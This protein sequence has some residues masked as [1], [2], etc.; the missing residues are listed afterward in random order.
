MKS[1]KKSMVI[2]TVLMVLLLIVAL[3][4]ATFAWYSAQ[5]NASVTRTT[6]SSASSNS[7][8]LVVDT[9]KVTDKEAHQSTV[10][11]TM[12]ANVAPMMLNLTAET[13]LADITYAD[14]IAKF[15]TY[16][17]DNAGNYSALP[18]TATPGVI[19]TVVGSTTA[20]QN[21]FWVTNVGGINA[22][23]TANVNIILVEYKEVTKTAGDSVAG[24]YVADTSEASGYKATAND[25]V[26]VDGTTYFEKVYNNENLRVAIFAG[27]GTN[28]KLVG[29]W[30]GTTSFY[31]FPADN[32]GLAVGDAP[33]TH[34][35]LTTNVKT[36]AQSIGS[37]V[38]PMAGVNI[39]IVA[40][41]E[42]DKQTNGDAGTNAYF[43]I[44]FDATASA[45]SN[46]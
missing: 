10:D 30:G 20:T 3:S 2:T 15:K 5:N 41:F 17:V 6:V 1:M 13:D 45:T 26:A 16:T 35:A 38:A 4:T 22:D 18:A 46:S 29:I 9:V 31:N 39:Q 14:F 23:I 25:A 37:N 44:A 21:S 43:T 7:A 12:T 28:N 33:A 19:T 8:S 36:S 24:L 32:S 40:W 34:T 42:G 11:L 27:T